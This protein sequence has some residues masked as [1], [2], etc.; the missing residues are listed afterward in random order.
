[1]AG[2][3]KIGKVDRPAKS[4]VWVDRHGNVWAKPIKGGRKRRKKKKKGKKRGGR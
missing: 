2:K 4:L 1:M 3:R